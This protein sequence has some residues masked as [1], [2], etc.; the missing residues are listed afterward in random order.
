MRVK[1]KFFLCLVEGES[2]F[3]GQ[4]KKISWEEVYSGVYRPSRENPVLQCRIANQRK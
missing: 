2:T 3:G 4:R 1:T